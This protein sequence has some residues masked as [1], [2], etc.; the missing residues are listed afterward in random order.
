VDIDTDGE[1]WTPEAIIAAGPDDDDPR[2]HKFLVKWAGY[3]H[4]ENTWETYAHM[5]DI[6]PNL[7]QQYYDEHPHVAPD[8]RF[9]STRRRGGRGG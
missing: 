8:A 5:T 6:G 9:N 7:V 4:D 2:H 3:G 1:G